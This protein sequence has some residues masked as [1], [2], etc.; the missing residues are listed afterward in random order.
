M[1]GA[2][3]AWHRRTR[4]DT[5]P[6]CRRASRARSLRCFLVVRARQ[7]LIGFDVIG[8]MR[9]GV[10]GAA[11]DHSEADALPAPLAL[12]GVNRYS[13]GFCGISLGVQPRQRR[14]HLHVSQS[15]NRTVLAKN[16]VRLRMLWMTGESPIRDC[17]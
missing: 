2:S 3:V 10:P 11:A 12:Y 14:N 9:V 6:N 16:A 7:H 15:A 4:Y 5:R 13:E 17:A 1:L 8:D